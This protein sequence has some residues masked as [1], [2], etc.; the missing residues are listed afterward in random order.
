MGSRQ[1]SKHGA[2][3]TRLAAIEEMAGALQGLGRGALL[4]S[5][6][7]RRSLLVRATS[8]FCLNLISCADAVWPLPSGLPTGMNLLCSD[9]TG[10]LTLNK[11]TS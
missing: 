1:L 11:V 5:S 6:G 9:K 4:C 10:T 8:A 7:G 3:V 2:I